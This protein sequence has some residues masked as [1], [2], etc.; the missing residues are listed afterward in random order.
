MLM[1]EEGWKMQNSDQIRALLVEKANLLGESV[2]A[3]PERRAEIDVA[4]EGIDSTVA[5]LRAKL[6]QRS[7]VTVR[8][9]RKVG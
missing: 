7:L 9:L 4:M 6:E 8:P 3:N 2:R 1:T 5:S